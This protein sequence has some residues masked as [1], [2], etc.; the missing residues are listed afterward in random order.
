MGSGF[1]AP[2]KSEFDA[3]AGLM[4]SQASHFGELDAWSSKQCSDTNGLDAL[5]V[6]PIRYLAPEVASFFTSKLGQ[7]EAGMTGVAGKARQTGAA[8]SSTEAANVAMINKIYGT[9]LPGFPDLG[10]IPGL[11]HVG[12]F[13]DT[14]VKLTEP[15]PAGDTTAKD[16][17]HQLQALRAGGGITGNL[18]RMGDN[19]FKFFTGQSLVEILLD[20]IFGDY[21]R[22]KYLSD[23]YGQLSDGTYT[24]TGT[25]RKGSVHLAGEWQGSAATA[26]DSLMFRWSMGSGGIGDAAEV[27]SHVYHDAYV[28]IV[29]LVQAALRAITALVNSEVKQLVETALGDAA[30]EAAGG[31]P[32]DPVADIVA[33]FWTIYKIIRI[34]SGII[35]AIKVIEAIFHEISQAVDKFK[36]D[37]QAVEA[38]LRQPGPLINVGSLIS[39]FEQRG[40]EFEKDSGWDPKLGAARIALLPSP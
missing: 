28:T 25:I 27:A 38:F 4:T 2:P 35:S 39:Q 14:P 1:V 16:I 7:C 24:V 8:Y 22:I 37:I 10:L 29:G 21:G 32:E 31:G 18:L 19:I 36:Q 33:G 34:I 9:P 3:Y 17:S 6:L 40:F 20:P 23:A 13:N 30:I 12:D 15:D 5:L 26:F 11:Q